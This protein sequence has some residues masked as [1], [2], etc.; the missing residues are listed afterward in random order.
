MIDVA[1]HEVHVLAEGK[2]APGRHVVNWNGRTA[3]GVVAPG[4]YFVSYLKPGGRQV[5]KLVMTR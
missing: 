1:G 2:F 5:R 3:R 4:I